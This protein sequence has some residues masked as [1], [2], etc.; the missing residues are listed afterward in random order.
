MSI[1]ESRNRIGSTVTRSI[2]TEQQQS[3]DVNSQW[4]LLAAG[5]A[6]ALSASAVVGHRGAAQCDVSTRKSKLNRTLSLRGHISLEEK[7]NIEWDIVL[8]E[9]AYGSVHPARLAATGEKL[10]LKKISKRYTN[11]STFKAEVDALKRIFEMGGHPNI[12]GLRDMYDSDPNYFYLILDLVSGGELFEHLINYGAYSEQDAARLVYEVASALAFLHGVGVVHADLKPENLLLCSKNRMDGTIKIIDFGCAIVSD[13]FD[14]IPSYRH[15]EENGSFPPVTASTGTTAYWPPERFQK[16]AVADAAMDMWSVGV[17]LYVMLT[18]VHPFDVHADSSDDQIEARILRDP[19]PPIRPELTG[20]LSESA[21]D[22]IKKLMHKDP[23]KRMTAR[24]ML[25]NPWVRGETAS[26]EKMQDSD[27]RLSQFK[28]TRYELE[29]GIFGLLVKQ[30]HRDVRLSEAKVKGGSEFEH[31]GSS[32]ILKRAFALID[33]GGKGYI[34]SD[35]LGRVAKEQANIQVSSNDTRELLSKQGSQQDILSFSDFSSLFSGLHHEHFPRGHMIFNAGDDGD[36]MYFLASGKVLIQTRKGQLVA[37]LKTGDFFGEGSLLSEEAKR[38]TSAKCATPVD[39]IQIKRADFNRYISSSESTKNELRLKWRARNLDYAKNL[40]RLDSNV[41]T[42]EYS[43][44]EVV[45]KEGDVGQDMYHVLENDG[46]ILEVSHGNQVVHQYVNGDSFG[47]T[48]LLFER[49]RSSTVT[50][51]SDKC[52]LQVMSG[53]D[54]RAV[55]DS[56]PNMA[57]ALKNM[58]RKRLFKRAIKAYSLKQG[59]S[60]SNEDIEKTFVEAD[61]DQ[62]GSLNLDEVAEI[63]TRMD[64]NFPRSEIEALLKYIDVDEDGKV[65]IEEFRRLFR[66]FEDV[67]AST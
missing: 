54:F 18:G 13:D 41:R 51:V 3:Q 56:N 30:G 61:V 62:S 10:A 58:C 12:S 53:A 22:L 9:G 11:S 42:N 46:G 43:K 49:P 47:E 48:S 60:L 6:L 23:A 35:D 25:K 64:T 27:K 16:G 34:N 26:K 39:V 1:R 50:C 45:Y 19:T 37:T 33:A 38:F 59:R 24:Q 4:M 17:I 52:L 65:S 14:D 2:S 66:Q 21:I 67:K 5:V 55:V 29:A 8:G 7:Y 63:M 44:G 20:H 57:A 40:I 28:D 36:A 15:T 31:L 32:S